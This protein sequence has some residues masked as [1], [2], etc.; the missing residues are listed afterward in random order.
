MARRKA[1]FWALTALI[2]AILL[3]IAAAGFFLRDLSQR[4]N[5]EHTLRSL[6]A[7]CVLYAELNNGSYPPDFGTLLK[8][9]DLPTF[10]FAYR[11]STPAPPSNLTA[12]QA[13]AWVNQNSRYIYTGAG[14]TTH[15]D[16]SRLVAYEKGEAGATA[17]YLLFADGHVERYALD[18]ARRIIRQGHAG[19]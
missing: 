7:V 18:D 10:L 8:A 15:S 17:L 4:M 2:G 12:D 11:D 19:N 16:P 5:T 9:E 14:L 1:I 6:G 13:A 3:L